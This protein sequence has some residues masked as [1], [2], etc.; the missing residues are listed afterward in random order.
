MVNWRKFLNF[1]ACSLSVFGLQLQL[2]SVTMPKEEP[3][4]THTFRPRCGRG[5]N[6]RMCPT[7][8]STGIFA[9]GPGKYVLVGPK[10]IFWEHRYES[11]TSSSQ[12][13]AG[14][15]RTTY[16]I[17][18]PTCSKGLQAIWSVGLIIVQFID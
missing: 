8:G 11:A 3:G 9:C 6:T 18:H 17:Q 10:L 15:Q 7:L 14:H 1:R 16:N 12:I 5:W 4:Q 2:V 13:F